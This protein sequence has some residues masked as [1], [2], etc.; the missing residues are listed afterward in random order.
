[1]ADEETVV[2]PTEEVAVEKPAETLEDQETP[3]EKIEVESETTVSEETPPPRKKTAK[4]RIDEITRA[5]REAE[6]EREYWK[7][8]ALEKQQVEERPPEPSVTQP[9]LPPRPTLDQFETTVAYEDALFEWRDKVQAIKF[10][11][12]HARTAQEEALRNF[13]QRAKKLRKEHEDFDEVIESPVFSPTM[14]MV[15]LNSESGPTIAYHLGL[16]ENRDTAERIRFLPPDMQI[17]EIGKLETKILLAQQT[18]K[19]P[20]APSPI[21]PVGMIGGTEVDPSKMTIEEWMAWDKQKTL[22]K[23]KAKYG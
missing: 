9:Q 21:K 22:E 10:A 7:G 3:A 20:S 23:L 1:M 16:P 2:T 8:V 14:R 19:V 18:R 5:R 13:S 12:T 6:R 11:E 4:E 15:L 17:Y